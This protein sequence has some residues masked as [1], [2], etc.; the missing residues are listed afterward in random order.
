MSLR[1]RA[2]AA[3]G[4]GIRR[5]LEVRARLVAAARRV[6]WG[7]LAITLAGSLF[8]AYYTVKIRQWTV[9]SDELQYAKLAQSIGDTLSPIPNIRGAYTGSLAQLYP[10]LM[11]PFIHFFSMPTA[12]RALH[13]LN[14]VLMASTAIPAYLLTREVVPSKLAAY[15]V[16]AL[17]ISIPWMVMS[18]MLLT[19]VA[20]YP[21]FVWAILALQRA[22]AR[23]TP[24]RD[25]LALGGLFLA[26]LARTQFLILVPIFAAAIVLHEAGWELTQTRRPLRALRDGAVRAVRGHR[27]LAWTGGLG[28]AVAALLALAGK[29]DQGLG[30]YATTVHG[31][32]L[33]PH[34]ILSATAKHIDFVAVGIGVVPF[35]LAAAWAF[36]VLVRPSKKNGHAFAVLSILTVAAVAFEATSFNLRFAAG[37]PI[38]DRYLFYIVP[39]LFVG[40]VACLL[41]ERRRSIAVLVVGGLFAWLASITTYGPTSLLFFASPDTVWHNVLQGRAWQLGNLVGAHLTATDLIV[42]GTIVLS[43][44]LAFALRRLPRNATLGVVG[45]VLLVYCLVETA[46]VFD[47]VVPSVNNGAPATL[48]GRDWIDEAVPAGTKV[49]AVVAPI[50]ANWDGAPRVWGPGGTEA[51]WQDAEFWNKS[52]DRVYLYGGYGAYA[53]FKNL[54]FSLDYHTGRVAIPEA[55]PVTVM[56]ASDVRFGLALRWSKVYATGMML[57]RP[58]HPYHA[59]WAT[60]GLSADGWTLGGVPAHIRLYP[61]SGGHSVR[62]RL[63]IIF[64]SEGE[65]KKARQVRATLG[66]VRY[67]RTLGRGKQ[68]I[69]TLSVCVPANRPLDGTMSASTPTRHGPRVGFRITR[70][71]VSGSGARCAPS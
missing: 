47:K 19:E 8:V 71:R 42:G 16:A 25:L 28:L 4:A 14:A 65:V 6:N 38:Q 2:V 7:L 20:A 36:S 51:V 3:P 55:R 63:A 66:G 67:T 18:T 53:P 35:V 29:L 40:M 22:L 69:A 70:I 52:I 59:I 41:D 13:G 43:I 27:V 30:R 1:P 54:P 26:F 45:A 24:Q 48:V 12:F 21:A 10:L 61:S 62:R 46:Y 50:N 39:L 11:A 37:G 5:Q 23:P 9:M 31:G 34:G 32:H 44:V 15:L 58:A 68:D 49:G 64:Q 33:L 60:R 57:L 56:S 17:T